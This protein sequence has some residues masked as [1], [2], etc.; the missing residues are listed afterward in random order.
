[1]IGMYKVAAAI[2]PS[3]PVM[4]LLASASLL[5]Q[6]SF[7]NGKAFLLRVRFA[8]LCVAQQPAQIECT[9]SLHA[10]VGVECDSTA[11]GGK[12]GRASSGEDA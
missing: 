2:V 10:N 7:L 3:N 1:V 6:A 12:I 9:T 8:S 4:Q 11:W 5:D